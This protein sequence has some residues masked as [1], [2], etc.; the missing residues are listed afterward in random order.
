MVDAP[1]FRIADDT[2]EA[3]RAAEALF[4]VVVGELAPILPASAAILHVGATAVPGCLTKGDLDIVVRVERADFAPAEARLAARFDRNG[5]SI[6]TD[7]F[8]AF[9]DAGRS[10]HLG[11]QLT[12]RGGPFDVFHLFAQ[13]LRDDPALLLRYN[14]LKLRFDQGPMRGY[15]SAKDAFVGASLRCGGMAGPAADA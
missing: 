12:V 7:D 13:A 14:A 6:R 11:I 8:A 15:R 5:G 2:E 10:P 4:A 1:T 9:E 3:R